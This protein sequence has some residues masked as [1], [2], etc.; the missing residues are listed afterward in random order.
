ME[1]M[2]VSVER[3]LPEGLVLV[4]ALAERAARL[5]QVGLLVRVP[6]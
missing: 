2:A 1:E 6:E 3:T 5:L 4:P